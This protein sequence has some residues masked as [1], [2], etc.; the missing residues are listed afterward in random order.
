MFVNFGPLL[1]NADQDGIGLWLKRLHMCWV[2]RGSLVH[3]DNDLARLVFSVSQKFECDQVH[4]QIVA[5]LEAL[6]HPDDLAKHLLLTLSLKMPQL[7]E[8]LPQHPNGFDSTH[9]D[10]PSLDVRGLA[11]VTVVEAKDISFCEF[12]ERLGKPVAIFVELGFDKAVENDADVKVGEEDAVDIVLAD[13]HLG[14]K[15]H[16]VF[17]S[18]A[19][20][21][22]LLLKFCGNLLGMLHPPLFVVPMQ[23][24]RILDFSVDLFVRL[25]VVH[26]NFKFV[27][28]HSS[29]AHHWQKQ[30]AKQGVDKI[31]LRGVLVEARV[32][33]VELACF[34]KAAQFA[35]TQRQDIVV[36]ID[37]CAERIGLLSEFRL[38]IIWLNDVQ[39]TALLNFRPL[40]FLNGSA[41]ELLGFVVPAQFE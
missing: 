10:T 12:T 38:N 36:V 30:E 39:G 5:I 40:H 13:L 8:V 28:N 32:R 18:E 17:D 35:E 2:D 20:E 41:H 6:L 24:E 9:T 1:L 27:C 15:L 4:S 14:Q 37:C 16:D 19:L 26:D 11:V 23:V 34:F 25:Q 7:C 3:G 22:R 21:K 29:V 31:D 33:Q